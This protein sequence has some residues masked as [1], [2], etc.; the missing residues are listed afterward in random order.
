MRLFT[1]TIVVAALLAG[2]GAADAQFA[3]AQRPERPYGGLFG[4]DTA[5]AEKLLTFSASFGGGYDDDIFATAGGGAPITGAGTAS[6]SS[7]FLI[8]SANLGYSVAIPKVTFQANFGTGAGHYPSLDHPNLVH[9]QAGV[10]GSF[11]VGRHAA[12]SFGQFENY[13]PLYFWSWLTLPAGPI[14]P[15]PVFDPGTMT[16]SDAVQAVS[17]GSLQP[18]AADA[19]AASNAE[20]YLASDTDV[21]YTQGLTQHLTFS[22]SYAYRRSDSPSGVRDF[23]MQSGS[24]MLSYAMAKG[25]ALRVGYSYTDTKFPKSSAVGVSDYTGSQINAGVDYSKPLS[26]SRRTMLSFS[27]GTSAVS[28]GVQTHYN[29]VGNVYLT[30]EMGRSWMAGV[31]YN[32]GVSFIETFQAPVLADS[33]TASIIGLLQRNMQFEVVGGASRGDV[34]FVTANGYTSYYATTGVRFAFTRNVGL[35]VFYGVFRYSFEN[36]VV[37]PPFTPRNSNRQTISF[38][39]DFWKPL[40]QRNRRSS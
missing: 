39:M 35:T 1:S 9:H 20:Y 38:S 16:I 26:V 13:Q 5:K 34:G 7:S 30:H 19:V 8:G 4:G 23:R 25:L 18:V 32:R 21:G 27:T 11:Q 37:L 15:I 22:A 10:S 36:G 28:D 31:G 17:L 14:D 12:F 29:I 40:I 24:G 3:P 6:P 2:A 33:A